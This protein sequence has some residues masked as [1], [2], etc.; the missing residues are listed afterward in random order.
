MQIIDEVVEKEGFSIIDDNA[1][2]WAIKKISE[3]KKE[4]K[5]IESLCDNMIES[6]K[7]RK[8]LAKTEYDNKTSY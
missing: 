7:L 8:E 6:Y 2:E 5:R 3:E 4:L 1:A